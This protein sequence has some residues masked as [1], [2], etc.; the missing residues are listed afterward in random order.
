MKKLSSKEFIIGLCVIVALVILFFGIDYLKGINLFKPAN[1]YVANYDNVAGLE[2]ASPVTI[3]G[4][5]LGQVREINFNYENPGKIEVLLAL[6]KDLQIPEGSVATIGSSLLGGG[7][8]NLTL[9]KSK[10]MIPVGGE[11][12]TNAA[13][14]LMAS[15]SKDIMPSVNS[16]LPKVDTLMTN[17]NMLTLNMNALMRH[18]ALLAS[19]ERLDG[20]TQNVLYATDGLNR[21]MNRDVPM[22]LGNANGVVYN[23]DTLTRSLG[24]FGYSL[25]QLPLQQ[26]MDNVQRLTAHLEAF[27]AQ[28][29]TALTDKNSTVGLL[30]S[31]PELYNRLTRMSAD[32]DSLI[33][34]IQRNPKRYISIKL[35]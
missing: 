23:L 7:S 32:V 24:R 1:F 5:K 17:L 15:L 14:D 12:G 8:I 33:L 20:I 31:D 18:Q 11:I 34:D 6:N 25:N 16:I 30:M 27:S 4:Y 3:D 21:T 28:L 22:I 9:G 10:K 13:P 2:V 26:S 19:M 29:N 35:F